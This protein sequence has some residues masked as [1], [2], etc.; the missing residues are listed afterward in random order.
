[1]SALDDYIENEYVKKKLREAGERDF[2]CVAAEESIIRRMLKSTET[3]EEI[4][5]DLS[6]TDFS[7]HDYGRVFNVIQ[8]LIER[9]Q[10][11]DKITVSN[12]AKSIFPKN[13]VKIAEIAA[14]MSEYKASYDD[15]RN[16]ADHVKI[17][18]DLSTR[19]KAIANFDKLTADL[20]D[21]EQDIGAILAQMQEAIDGIDVVNVEWSTLED[22][23]L[24][25]FIYLEKRSKGDIKSLPSGIKP[26]DNL[27]GG[28]FD[29][30]MTV[31]GARPSGGKTAFGM[32][33]AIKAAESG[34]KVGFVSCEMS[35]EGVGQRL[36]SNF[37]NVDGMK[38]RKAELSDDDWAALSMGMEYVSANNLSVELLYDTNVI[39]D[40]VHAVK[41]KARHKEIEIVIIDYLQFMDSKRRFKDERLKV[42][43]MTKLLKKLAKSA[44]IPVILLSQLTREGE[45][46]MPTMKMLLE[47]G[48]IEA[49]AD[50][51]M[52]LHSPKSVD[53]KAIDPR[54]KEYFHNLTQDGKRYLCIG[55]A[56]QRNGAVGQ[57]C[58]VFDTAVMRYIQIDRSKVEGK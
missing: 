26:L 47:S 58:V 11:I 8:T 35:K 2:T 34:R 16:I 54:D 5:N 48:K 6:G 10:G 20:H 37:G 3:S 38:L 33:V 22:T 31:V 53:D 49:D 14:K 1:M 18:K 42:S 32:N 41:H 51:I 44:K 15:S 36:L 46:Q 13:A 39:E 24:T 45:G 25:A 52:F 56:K 21:P 7:N 27:M 40:I 9:H 17:V 29:S 23:L 50:N 30:E 57:V 43:Y 19:R 55:V 4:A 12:A 28:F